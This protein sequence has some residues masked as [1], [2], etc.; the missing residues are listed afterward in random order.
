VSLFPKNR[1]GEYEN[2]NN[3]S[4]QGMS[5]GNLCKTA[6]VLKARTGRPLPNNRGREFT[7][8]GSG[9]RQL[10]RR[11]RCNAKVVCCP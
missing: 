4:D 10:L 6:G 3:F 7:G 11:F 9:L 8:C 1:I 2:F 5:L